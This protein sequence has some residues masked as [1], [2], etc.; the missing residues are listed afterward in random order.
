MKRIIKMPFEKNSFIVSAESTEE[1]NDMKQWLD[2]NT[3]WSGMYN[4]IT[5]RD[6]N[7]AL[8]FAIRWA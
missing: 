8:M 4:V 3:S 1:W 7:H 5:F 2:E 6:P